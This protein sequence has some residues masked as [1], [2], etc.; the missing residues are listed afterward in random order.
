MRANFHTHTAFCDGKDTPAEMA[1]RAFEL[2]LE[3]LGFTGHSGGGAD[4]VGMSDAASAAYRVEI[5][6]LR[7]EYAGRMEIYC[8]IEQD[9]TSGRVP[10]CY[11][12][13]IGSVHYVRQNGE[14]LCVDW[15]PER[16]RENI[17]RYGGDPYAYAEAY[18]AAVGG[19]IEQTG[20]DIV[21]HFDL[22]RKFDEQDPVF[23]E[24]NL[25][26]RRAV[27]DALE[28]LCS[29]GSRPVFEINT[30]AMARG[31]RSEPYPSAWILREIRARSCPIMITSDCHDREKLTFGYAAAAE[32]ARAAGYTSQITIK[33]GVFAEAPL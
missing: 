12:Y 29:G 4:D 2:G 9:F 18:F 31:Y 11:D 25:G 28:R 21:G 32:L 30:G 8:G 7:D 24:T 17:K 19:V 10:C 14:H 33:R 3:A 15:S 1:A 23:D 26:Y 13:A 22:I 20:A 27:T 5:S 16:T 6:R